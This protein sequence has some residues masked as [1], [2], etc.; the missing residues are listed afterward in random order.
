VTNAIARVFRSAS[1]SGYLQRDEVALNSEVLKL[2]ELELM[3]PQE[4]LSRLKFVQSDLPER[5]SGEN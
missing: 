1:L 5:E 4:Q 2:N 3:I